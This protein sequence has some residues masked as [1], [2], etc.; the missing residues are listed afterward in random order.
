[1]RKICAKAF[2]QN[3]CQVNFLLL[4][5]WPNSCYFFPQNCTDTGWPHLGTGVLFNTCT[6]TNVSFFKIGRAVSLASMR[7]KGM[8]F[9]TGNITTARKLAELMR[10]CAFFPFSTKLVKDIL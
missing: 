8:V 4:T 6:P 7:N 5:E 10:S 2:D 9:F 3:N 1:M